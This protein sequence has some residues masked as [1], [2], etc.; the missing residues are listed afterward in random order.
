VSDLYRGKAL[1]H[2]PDHWFDPACRRFVLVANDERVEPEAVERLDLHPSDVVVQFN[3]AMHA[4]RF[5]DFPGHKVFVFQKNGRGFYWGFD[6]E[7]RL[8]FD[9]FGEPRASLTLVFTMRMIDLVRPFVEALPE[10]VKVMCFRPRAV[11]LFATPEGKV[12]SVGFI[13]LSYLH[14]LNM[15]RELNGLRAVKL[16]TLGFTGVYSRPKVF[17]GHDFAY[18]QAV[19]ATW[20]DVRRLDFVGEPLPPP[21]WGALKRGKDLG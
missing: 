11:P 10:E 1:I 15:M 13:T 2:A 6:S 8:G 12:A 7:G 14:H 19:I 18:E 20:P 4:P 16:V 5:A 3:K 17:Q 21:P 9:P